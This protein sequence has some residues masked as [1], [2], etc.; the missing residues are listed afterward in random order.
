MKALDR[1]MEALPLPII[2]AI[3]LIILATW[4]I[5]ELR[6]HSAYGHTFRDRTWIITFVLIFLVLQRGFT[7]VG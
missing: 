3:S 7:P 1:L 5:K 6:G 2:V 4:L